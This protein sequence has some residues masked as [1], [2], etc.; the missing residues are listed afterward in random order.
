MLE[1]GR[2]YDDCAS[3]QDLLRLWAFAANL[4]IE[5][6]STA[7]VCGGVRQLNCQTELT[8]SKPLGYPRRVVVPA[9]RA[10]VFGV[11]LCEL[12]LMEHAQ[13]EAERVSIGFVE[14]QL[15]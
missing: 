13:V 7:L 10:I 9:V 3:R 11:V 5:F 14:E 4:M 2:E 1:E 6:K 12:D 8:P 15:H